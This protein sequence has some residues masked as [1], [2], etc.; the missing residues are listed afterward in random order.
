MDRAKVILPALL[1]LVALV[2]AHDNPSSRIVGGSPAISGQF[3]SQVAIQVGGTV[4]CGGTV[5]NQN[6]ILTAAS[7]IL[8]ANNN[9]V[10]AAQV[11]VR[12]GE[13][14]FQ[15]TQLA[16]AVQRIFAHPHYNPWTF[17]NDIAV[18]RLLNNISFP[19]VATPAVAPAELN[20]RIVADATACEVVGWN[21]TPAIPS[22]PLQV[23]TVTV[24][25]RATCDAMHN[26]ILQTTML[27]TQYL[28]ATQGVCAPARG[29]GLYCNNLLTGVVSF[30]FGCGQNSTM[31]VYTQARYYDLW[32]Q[33]QFNRTDT[34]VAGPTPAP[35][36]EGGP[37]KASG[38]SLSVAVVLVALV[39]AALTQQ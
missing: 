10:Q 36:V 34:P 38:L 18:L 37:G 24:A 2:T 12:A 39:S 32:I 26:G 35:G 19:A 22:V 21:W 30:G 31:T 16:L 5:L 1:A 27:C 6:H 11:T 8:D 4:F 15:P 13:V 14:V 29:G 3:P 17:E 28:Q 25:P 9:L 33:Q 7:C 20:R 23:L